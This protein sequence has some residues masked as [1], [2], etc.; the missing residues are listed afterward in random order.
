MATVTAS[1]S[2]HLDAPPERVLELLRDYR[3]ARPRILTDNYSAY[4][5]EAGGDG[6]GTVLAYHFAAGGR[7]RD[8]R[9][10][11]EE[12]EGALRERD[13]LS[14]FVATWSVTPAGSGSEVTLEGAWNGAG[15]VGGAFERLFAPLGLRRIY[16]AILSRL[17]SELQASA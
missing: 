4:R 8:Y 7:E 17:A 13:Q 6:A 3:Q 2:K 11:V 9:L 12:S 10:R 1:A 5:I 14:S 15:G 16:G